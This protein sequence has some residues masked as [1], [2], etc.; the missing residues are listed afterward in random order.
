[1]S[2]TGSIYRL[3]GHAT[4]APQVS[5]KESNVLSDGVSTHVGSIVESAASVSDSEMRELVLKKIQ[6]LPPLPKTLMDIYA[7]RNSDYPDFDALLKIIQTDPMIVANLLKISNSVMYGF[8]RQ[9]K[10]VPDVL[11]IL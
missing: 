7:L 4:S 3:P 6:N 5:I 9:I 8:S 2:N 10:A 11:K 1:M